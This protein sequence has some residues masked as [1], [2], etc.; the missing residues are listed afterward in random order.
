MTTHHTVRL[1]TTFAL[2]ALLAA[3]AGAPHGQAP[4]VDQRFGFDQLWRS[5]RVALGDFRQA[6]LG[7]VEVTLSRDLVSVQTG[8]RL[9]MSA[10][11]SERLRAL[12]ESMVVE[13]MTAALGEAGFTLV[14]RADAGTLLISVQL[15]NV[16]LSPAFH[17]T[18]QPTTTFT[19]Q[20]ARAEFVLLI[21]DA[22]SGEELVRA[23]D[24]DA[25]R[26]DTDLRQRHSMEA[27][28]DLEILIDRW[29]RATARV[30]SD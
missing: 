12:V 17:D 26:E 15:E 30:L 29:A 23:R 3:C 18:P 6:R 2:A 11:D 5:P 14:D 16:H 1:L 21:K 22:S 19:R 10:R 20:T 9:G 25:S 4:G 8:S 13:R 28:A 27:R 24:R 7:P